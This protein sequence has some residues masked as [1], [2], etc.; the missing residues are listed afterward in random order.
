MDSQERAVSTTHWSRFGTHPESFL[1]WF[2]APGNQRLLLT[3][4]VVAFAVETVF[5]ATI[6]PVEGDL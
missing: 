6:P 5:L 2:A 1:N 3:L 4:G